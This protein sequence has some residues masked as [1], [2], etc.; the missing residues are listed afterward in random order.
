MTDAIIYGG[1]IVL[2]LGA[3]LIIDRP[4]RKPAKAVG[5]AVKVATIHTA[6]GIKHTVTLGKK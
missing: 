1:A 2:I 3:A 5:H 4:L 6:H